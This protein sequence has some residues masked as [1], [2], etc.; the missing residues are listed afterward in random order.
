MKSISVNVSQ[1]Y[2]CSKKKLFLKKYLVLLRKCAVNVI[3][4]DTTYFR[5]MYT[6]LHE[7]VKH[8]TSKWQSDMDKFSQITFSFDLT[9]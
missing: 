4:Y 9:Q 8:K 3:K 5:L 2:Y 7:N 6:I 1:N